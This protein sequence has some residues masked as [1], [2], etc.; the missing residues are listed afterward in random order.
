MKIRPVGAEFNADRW[1]DGH[2]ANS[3]F[4]QFSQRAEKW[5][6][7]VLWLA[8]KLNSEFVPCSRMTENLVWVVSASSEIPSILREPKVHYRIYRS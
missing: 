2:E 5:Q 7:K 6:Q 8:N 4:S 3:Q 1:R